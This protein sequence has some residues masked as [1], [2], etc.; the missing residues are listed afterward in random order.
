MSTLL[1]SSDTPEEGLSFLYRWLWGTM[2]LLGTEL[3]TSGRAVRAINSWAISPANKKY[4][5]AVIS[6]VVSTC[7]SFR[8]P[9]FS[10]QNPCQVAHL[11]TPALESQ[12]MLS[13]APDFPMCITCRH[14]LEHKV[15][16]TNINQ[17]TIF[18][19]TFFYSYQCPT[20]KYK[21]MPV[22]KGLEM[23]TKQ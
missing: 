15:L 5:Y 6:A 22:K 11:L 2:W 8:D 12:W 7:F 13:S 3:R 18:M 4:L 17:K 21:I 23:Y 20:I 19:I 16:K 9:E 1:L 10:S 14:T